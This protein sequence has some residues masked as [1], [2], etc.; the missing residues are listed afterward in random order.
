ML[1]LRILASRK[2]ANVLECR[3]FTIWDK[4]GLGWVS[5]IIRC[6]G[7]IIQVSKKAVDIG[8]DEIQFDY[9][10]FSNSRMKNADFGIEAEEKQNDII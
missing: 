10:R 2:K 3:W 4:D 7:Y 1:H 8:F 6:V 5:L 9:I